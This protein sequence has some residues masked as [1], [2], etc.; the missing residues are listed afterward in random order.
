MGL[1]VFTLLLGVVKQ[2]TKE[3][4]NPICLCLKNEFIWWRIRF[5]SN[6]PP[7]PSAH[8]THARARR[9]QCWPWLV[10][11][12]GPSTLTWLLEV[13]RYT[14]PMSYV[15]RCGVYASTV[16]Y[17]YCFVTCYSI[18]R[19]DWLCTYLR[20]IFTA[21][22]PHINGETRCY[23]YMRNRLWVSTRNN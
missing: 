19:F 5:K 15:A 2:F 21:P 3:K 17:T 20:K 6:P 22:A 23:W 12:M 11:V 8:H 18:I 1:Y 4:R 7:P 13:H 10:L 9:R 14:Y 16:H